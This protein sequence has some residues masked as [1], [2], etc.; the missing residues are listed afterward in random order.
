M[1]YQDA[2][3]E[4]K[5]VSSQ[6][7][8]N[9]GRSQ[10]TDLSPCSRAHDLL[11]MSP[12]QPPA[13]LRPLFAPHPV[14][15]KRSR[16]CLDEH[17]VEM[18]LREQHP[19]NAGRRPADCTGLPHKLYSRFDVVG[20]ISDSMQIMYYQLGYS[21]SLPALLPT[22]LVLSSKRARTEAE[23]M[24][25]A[26]VGPVP[27][28][29]T[30]PLCVGCCSTNPADFTPTT[31]KSHLVCKCGVVSSMI[32]ISTAR[33]KNC[34][35]DDDKTT[36]ADQPYEPRTDRFD[37]PAQSC[38]ELRNQREREATGTR[39]SKKAK[40]KLGVGWTQE[41]AAREAARAE[42]QRQEM[43]PPDQTKGQHIQVELDKLF[44][45]LEPLDN[46]IKRFCRMEADRAWREAVRHCASCEARGRCQLRIKEKG[47][48]V[49]AD[50]SLTCSINTLVDG[51]VMLDG[52]THAGLLVVANKLGAQQTHKGTSCAL[53][54]V[55]TIVSTLQA[56]TLASPIA[57]C[58]VVSKP[59][60]QPSPAP[61]PAP[62][63]SSEAAAARPPP[64]APFARTDSSVS[65]LGEQRRE[66]GLLKLR[67]AIMSVF[68]CLG[69]SMPCS[70]RDTALTVIQLPDFRASLD[71]ALQE[72]DDV[73]KLPTEGLAFVLLEAVAYQLNPSALR[74]RGAAA[75]LI[76]SFS[77]PLG[78]LEEA[79]A[80]IRTML[81][82]GIAHTSI[83][84]EDGLF[85]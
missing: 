54:A 5:A 64:P 3:A 63:N 51:K 76:P 80:A 34:A 61:S 60:S 8:R 84:D 35:R 42:R 27:V 79:T 73:S 71:V 65:D 53:R 9:L 50:A 83:A 56:H 11:A 33:E 17:V 74:R 30:A 21:R 19:L 39:I 75:A 18:V 85:S 26:G 36:H 25:A 44:T 57:S 20:P 82:D 45:A 28:A 37:H 38:D 13:K 49:I 66:G 68:R 1:Q 46:Q 14:R 72:N 6:L 2:A 23:S 10:R 32:T 67:D 7:P 47:P 24:H 41:Y 31:D 78:R 81:P 43:S 77:V 4:M 58:P 59:S 22:Q 55:R 52:V 69:T 12:Q 40:Q 48:A 15:P 16:V 29:A 70:V 62:S